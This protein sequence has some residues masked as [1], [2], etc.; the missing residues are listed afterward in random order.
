MVENADH[1]IVSTSVLKEYA[2]SFNPNVSMITSPVKVTGQEPRKAGTGITIGWIGSE[3]TSKY[4]PSLLPVFIRLR[5]N[6]PVDFLFVGCRTDVLPEIR[7][8]I[9]PWS[10]E[11]ESTLL[12]RMD[13][14]IMPLD[15]GEF[16]RGKGGYKLLQYMAAG[17]PV[18][19]SP[20]GINAEI[21]QD[22]ENGFLCKNQEEWFS[23]LERLIQEEPLRNSMG[24]TGYHMVMGKYSLEV[25]FRQLRQ[26]IEKLR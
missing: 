8:E 20:V 4:L 17:L 12:S 6:Y 23:S 16:E 2:L 13:I 18:V 14:G 11:C 10:P 5:E 26:I 1:V 21:V 19:A 7:P 9:V 3:W 25:C 24:V 15:D 22:G